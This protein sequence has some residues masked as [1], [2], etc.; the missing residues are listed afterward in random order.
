MLDVQRPCVTECVVVERR[1]VHEVPDRK[2]GAER[3]PWAQQRR[4]AARDRRAHLRR[5][6]EH[7]QRRRP[8]RDHHVAEQVEE[9]EVVERDRLERRAE[10]RDDED[11]PECEDGR[12]RAGRVVRPCR[13][14]VR[15]R[16]CDGE[17]QEERLPTER[18]GRR[19]HG[20]SARGA[21][22]RMRLRNRSAAKSASN[23]TA[24]TMMITRSID[25]LDPFGFGGIGIGWPDAAASRATALTAESVSPVAP[26]VTFT[27]SSAEASALGFPLREKPSPFGITTSSRPLYRKTSSSPRNRAY[28]FGFPHNVNADPR[29]AGAPISATLTG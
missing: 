15:D 27:P 19:R 1:Q 5:Q 16:G 29:S 22:R 26:C 25:E 2:P 10:S 9:Q 18:P 3:Q 7:E 4:G 8:V 6:A 24:A 28:C 13:A 11:E 12:A 17:C 23:A 14:G 20:S 21:P